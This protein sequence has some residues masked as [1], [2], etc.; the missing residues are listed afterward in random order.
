MEA[1][2]GILLGLSAVFALVR[3][4]RVLGALTAMYHGD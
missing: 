3:G 2:E 4:M 1:M